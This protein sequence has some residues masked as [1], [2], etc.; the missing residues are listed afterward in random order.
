MNGKDER[1]NK[2][3]PLNHA[4]RKGHTEIVKLLIAKGA[5]VNAVDDIGKNKYT[6]LICA[7]I[8]GQLEVAKLLIAKGANV[9]ATDKGDKKWTALNYASKFKRNNIKRLLM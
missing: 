1:G 7:S 4:S 9:N 2:Y 3:L 5:D 8:N 6:P